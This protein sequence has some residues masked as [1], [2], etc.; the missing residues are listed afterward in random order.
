[1]SVDSSGAIYGEGEIN[2]DRLDGGVVVDGKHI[3]SS[4]SD[5]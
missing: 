3:Y 1:M 2:I 4:E 5:E